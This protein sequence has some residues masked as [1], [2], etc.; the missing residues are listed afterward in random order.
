MGCMTVV[1]PADSHRHSGGRRRFSGRNV[2]PAG[3]GVLRGPRPLA[4]RLPSP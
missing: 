1:I 2:H 4:A 3:L